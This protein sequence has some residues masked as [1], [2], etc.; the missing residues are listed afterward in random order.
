MQ[1][2]LK[3][4][5]CRKS[6]WKYH[7]ECEWCGTDVRWM[8]LESISNSERIKSSEKRNQQDEIEPSQVK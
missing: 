7:Q 2:K 5:N 6:G 3:Q 1:E 4:N 8:V